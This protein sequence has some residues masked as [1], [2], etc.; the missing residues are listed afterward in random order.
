MVTIYIQNH[1]RIRYKCSETLSWHLAKKCS[2][3][4]VF[5]R[6]ALATTQYY[7]HSSFLS[8][9]L[10]VARAHFAPSRTA[11]S[12]F[13]EENTS[14]NHFH[15]SFTCL[16][17]N[18]RML[19]IEHCIVAIYCCFSICIFEYIRRWYFFLLLPLLFSLSNG[20]N[21]MK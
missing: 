14:L 3:F 21:E 20:I 18:D 13:N 12:Q 11:T 10:L 16:I 19:T 15:V 8:H 2:F 5:C 7:Y 6:L 4:C 17:P 9:L 1:N